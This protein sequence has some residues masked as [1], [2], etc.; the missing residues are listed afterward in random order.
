MG[1]LSYGAILLL[2]RECF[3]AI[4]INIQLGSNSL[5]ADDPNVI[6]LTT[7]SYL[8]H[9]DYDPL[10]LANDIGLVEFRLPITYTGWVD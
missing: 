9:P 1:N 3:R 7:D 2:K 4:L 8:L 6:K 10:T 5:D